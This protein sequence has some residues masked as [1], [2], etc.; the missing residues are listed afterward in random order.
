MP[1]FSDTLLHFS[2]M[3]LPFAFFFRRHIRFRCHTLI[4]LLMLLRRQLSLRQRL[5]ILI[6][7]RHTLP[8]LYF[9]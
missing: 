6:D 4:R 8:L 3:P 5:M 1:L 2:F 9:L 7:F